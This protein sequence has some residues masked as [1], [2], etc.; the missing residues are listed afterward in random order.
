MG[1]TRE[2]K[3]LS[4]LYFF[5]ELLGETLIFPASRG[6]PHL[7]A[8]DPFYLQSQHG[9]SSS[10]TLNHSDSLYSTTLSYL[11]RP[12]VIRLV[13][14]SYSR[15][16]KTLNLI[17]SAKSPSS[18]VVTYSQALGWGLGCG[19]LEWAIIL[20]TTLVSFVTYVFKI[21]SSRIPFVKEINVHESDA[22]P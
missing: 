16:I 8:Y 3:V 17:T 20:P 22:Y 21:R 5:L 2:N 18:R 12:L 13:P 1:F 19:Q 9:R 11:R 14:F 7:L 10:P 6:K 4:L 15:L